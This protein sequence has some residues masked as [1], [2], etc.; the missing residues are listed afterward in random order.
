MIVPAGRSVGN[1]RRSVSVSSAENMCHTAPWDGRI[2]CPPISQS[3]SIC[4]L[5]SPST[6][7]APLSEATCTRRLIA[8]DM[9]QCNLVVP[10]RTPLS[11]AALATSESSMAYEAAASSRSNNSGFQAPYAQYNFGPRS[12]AASEGS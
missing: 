6:S 11:K 1:I 5:A 4:A 8:S 12:G 9:S 3:E 2:S 7:A 10:P